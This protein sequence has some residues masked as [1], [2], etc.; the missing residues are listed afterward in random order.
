[1]ML[2][3]AARSDAGR[4]REANEDQ[5]AI[6]DLGHGGGTRMIAVADG[7]GGHRAGDVAS[8]IALKELSEAVRGHSCQDGWLEVLRRGVERANTAVFQMALANEHQ[9]GMGTTLTAVVLDDGHLFLV[10]VGD[11]RAYLVRDGDMNPLTRDD[12]LVEELI[13]LGDITPDDAKD[14]PQKNV[15]TRAVGTRP[16]VN[17]QTLS[18]DL[19]VGDRIILCSDGLYG[20]VPDDRMVA[21][22][23][24]DGVEVGV[25]RL[26]DEAN[27]LGG[28]DNITVVAVE[29]ASL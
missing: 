2:R 29:V 18:I 6:L 4:V 13:R 5:Y 25:E 23:A 28:H 19:E 11:S 16:R 21:A 22:L 12:S 26:V 15:L 27:Q 14:H 8:S 9:A 20:L 7:M 24:R 10:H 1:M 3:V 17:I